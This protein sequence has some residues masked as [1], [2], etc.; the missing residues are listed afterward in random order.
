MEVNRNKTCLPVVAVDNVGA[1]AYNR[2]D[3]KH[4]L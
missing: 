2:Q 4:R 1:E 3:S